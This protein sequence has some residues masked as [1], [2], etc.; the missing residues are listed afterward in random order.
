MATQFPLKIPRRRKSK[1]HRATTSLERKW[2]ME[3]TKTCQGNKVATQT[4][5]PPPLYSPGAPRF[6][7]GMPLG[8]QIARQ[9]SATDPTSRAIHSQRLE[10]EAR[11]QFRPKPLP[12]R[13][14]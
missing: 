11:K 5:Q 4:R 2:I 6:V 1:P 12:R 3:I 7:T 8:E 13:R 14:R 10:S 9:I